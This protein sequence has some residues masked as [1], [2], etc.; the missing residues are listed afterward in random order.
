MYAN[1]PNP[2]H[3]VDDFK[4]SSRVVVEFEIMSRNFKASKKVDAIKAFF[5]RLLGIYLINDPIQITVST[6]EKQRQGEDK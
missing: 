3:D 1:Y 6:P 5:F 2:G 4:N